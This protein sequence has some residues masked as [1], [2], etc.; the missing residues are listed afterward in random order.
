MEETQQNI[1]V[2]AP[3]KINLFLHITGRRNDG[4]HMLQSL[5]GFADVGDVISIEPAYDFAFSIEGLFA[6]HLENENI[7]ENL[8][9]KAAKGLARIVDR[10]LDFR[11]S[12]MKNLPVCAG[13]GGGSADAAA[14]IWGLQEYWRLNRDAPYLWSLLMDL[15]ADVPVCLRCKPQI[16]EGIGE[17]LK[18]A[19]LMP[20]I[21]VLLVN[22]LYFCHTRD[23]FDCNCNKVY[24]EY[25]DIPAGFSSVF[26]MV[27]FLQNCE[28][29]LFDS[30]VS[31]LP[32]IKNVIAALEAQKDC[33]FAQMSG[34]GASCFGIFETINEAEK[35]AKIIAKNHPEWWV[36]AAWV[37]K[38]ERG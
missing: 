20:E 18:P 1:R 27:A 5:I 36:K 2:F 26:E 32:E 4:Y 24:R 3:A 37:N 12:L 9:V 33:L 11:I 21:P 16:V 29:G 22:P 30:A 13:L 31:V 25:I 15:G 34:S 35:A 8:V 6:K 19:P 38:F 7:D 14:T 17:E 10:P 23:V 28:N